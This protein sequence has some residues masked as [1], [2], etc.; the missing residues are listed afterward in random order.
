M[1]KQQR[2]YYRTFSENGEGKAKIVIEPKEVALLV[3]IAYFDLHERQETWFNS[4]IYAL[5]QKGFYEISYQEIERLNDWNVDETF[6]LLSF[7]GATNPCNII[8][9]YLKNLC[10]LYN[11]RV[12]YYKILQTQP[13]P[14]FEQIAPRGLLEFGNCENELLANWL[15]W[16]KWFYDIDNRSAQET[17]YIFE[18]IL[19]SCLGGVA[20]SA[21][22]SPVKRIDDNGNKTTQGR[23]IDCYVEERHEVYELKMRVTIAASG[24]GRFNEELTFPFEA[25]QAGLTPILVVFDGTEST[26]LTKL[27]E[28]YLKYD[29]KCCVGKDAWDILT[30][31]AGREMGMF[32]NKYIFPPITQ[33]ERY[34]NA[35]PQKIILSKD[36]DKIR[37]EGERDA[38]VFSRNE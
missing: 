22:H 33:M 18:P 28:Q 30:K 35:T 5:A 1:T 36:R 10:F 12:K 11:K 25:Q 13:F 31:N 9:L 19:V 21:S 27:Q 2:D 15:E 17:G 29:G 7:A 3:H 38:Y 8:Y 4:E 23:Q 32:I 20:V 26:L 16:R 24:Q 34:M 37:I 14:K 6:K